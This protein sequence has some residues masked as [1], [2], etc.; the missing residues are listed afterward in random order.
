MVE[1]KNSTKIGFNNLKYNFKDKNNVPIDFIGFK[2]PLH[3]F[4]SIHNGDMTLEDVEKEQIKL[5]S[6]LGHI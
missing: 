4:K 6:D 3:I 2:G 1:I 5:K